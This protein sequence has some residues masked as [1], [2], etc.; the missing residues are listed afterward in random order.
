[1]GNI[2]VLGNGLLGSAFTEYEIPVISH[3]DCDITSQFDIDAVIA[4]YRPDVIVNACGIVPKA[5]LHVMDAFR[6]NS[7]GPRLLAKACDENEIR[8][9]QIS[10]DCVFSGARG[11]YVEIDQVSPPD[12]Y[13]LSKTLGEITEFPH[14]TVRTSFVGL[15]DPK[16]RGLLA[17]AANEK[18]VMGYDK[19]FWNGLTHT[20]LARMLVEVII[21]MELSDVLHLYGETISKYELL[22]QA[23]MTLNLD[24]Q[25]VKESEVT[26]TPHEGNKTLSSLMPELQSKKTFMQML[27]E[28]KYG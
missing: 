19:V 11:G 21:P 25:L 4:K 18:V 12:S 6:V 17:W 9:V 22:K 24:Y 13:G 23:K 5:I 2:I 3:E 28:M 7:L 15:P 27:R 1:M 10:T 16:G 14:L 20:E 8:L 26:D